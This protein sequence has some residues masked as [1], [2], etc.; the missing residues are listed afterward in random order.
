MECSHGNMKSLNRSANGRS[1][2]L[3]LLA[4][5][6]ETYHFAMKNV[7]VSTVVVKTSVT[8]EGIKLINTTLTD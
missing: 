7:H 8:P 4:E 2:G 5:L 6:F 1:T 3:I